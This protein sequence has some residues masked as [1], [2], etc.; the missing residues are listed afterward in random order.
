MK[1]YS[2]ESLRNVVLLGGTRSGKT[3]LAEA[4]LF[5]GKVI[6]RRG[7]VEAKNTVS[8][9]TEVEQLYQRS[10][11][12]TPL[13]AEFLDHKINFIDAAGADDFIE[14]AVL[15]LNVCDSAVMVVNAGQ[16]VE[17]GT[18]IHG[19]YAE[20]YNK[21]VIIAVNQLDTE[22]ANWDNTIDSLH[23]AFGSKPVIIQFPVNPGVEFNAFIDI[24]KMKMYRF[25]DDN[26][27][28][29][30]LEIPADL[31]GKAE[32]MRAELME[33]AASS[34]EEL[35]EKFFDAGELTEEELHKGF[36]VGFDK[37]E[38]YPV[39]CT[40]G[41]KDIGVKRLME[42][43][44]EVAPAPKESVSGSTSLFVYKTALEQHLG[45]VTYFKVM[46]G[47]ITE[48]QDVVNMASGSKERIT[49]LYAVAGKKKEKVTELVAGDM[50]CTVKLKAV[51]TNQ[52]LNAPGNEKVTDPIAFPPAK[53][54]CAVKAVEEKDEE[55]L[56]EALNRASAED[57]TLVVEYSKELKQTIIN[58]QGEQHINILKWNINNNY[59]IDIELFAPKIPYRETI[60]KVANAT[61]RHKKQSGGAGQFGEVTLL[62]EPI[63]E[64]VDTLGKFKIDGKE[65]VMNIKSKEE[66]PLPWGGRWE[67]YNCV[68]GGAIDASFMPAIKKGL[69]QKME[70]GPLTGSYARDI[71]VFVYDGKMHPVDSKEIAFII[72]GRN[73]FK[74][75]FKNAGP[76]I[77]EPIYM[78]EIMVPG[79][80]VGDVMSDLQNRRGIMEGMGSE[81][82]FQILKARV[83]LAELYKYS[84]TLSSLTSGRATFTMNFIDYQQV[85][86][87]VQ[88]KLLKAYEA[89]A[90][91][92]D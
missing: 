68:V 18:E 59:K 1:N 69:M 58:G 32:D 92:E 4:M 54:R 77:M 51:K 10:I 78:V 37:G 49:T 45:D 63:V 60:T 39:F 38:V 83:P 8:D 35:M 22:K 50:G 30:E 48:G 88:D 71:R 25:K 19:R 52:T 40:C 46:E 44:T 24:F 62:I 57:P 42:F 34:D 82:G 84:T 81:K 64:G 15:G 66:F 7:T 14:G 74:D 6:D 16:G 72:A 87:D 28:R 3:T 26:G 20:Q 5:E 36:K 67:F 11:Y 86:M 76:K 70:E 90:K 29:E 43:I 33:M 80:C 79:D 2:T 27:T 56:G 85:P 21:P 75:A 9:N 53:Y 12:S 61:Y 73:A 17:V 13:Y 23:Q 89:E 41:K 31:K 65:Q 47:K 55:K 91:E